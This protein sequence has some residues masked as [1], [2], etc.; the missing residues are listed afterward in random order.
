MAV[1]HRASFADLLAAERPP[2]GTWSQIASEEVIDMLG[3]AGL[4]YTIV[5]M[6]HGAFGIKTAERLI[7]AC[8]AN[9]IVPLVRIARPDPFL[10]GQALDA[11]AAGIV[12]P[13]VE[14]AGAARALVAA[15]RYAPEGTRGACPCVRAG[16][17]FIRDWPAHVRAS[18]EAG[19]IA[20]VE[21]SKGLDAIEEICAVEGLVALLVGPFDLSVSLGH[22]GDYLHPDVDAAIA[23]M[24]AAARAAN[25]PVVA[26][27][28]DPDADRAR[29]QRD[30]WAARGARAFVVGTDKI[31]FADAMRRYRDALS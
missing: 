30:R 14:S 4:D 5:D 7:R 20:L 3:A 6:E 19:V 9:G 11:G 15:T 28:F 12:A 17:H 25:L 1:A 29:A 27:V 8:D 24:L 26:P 21:T 16:G 22:A 2:L 10:V 31:V 13:Q 23:R 18:R